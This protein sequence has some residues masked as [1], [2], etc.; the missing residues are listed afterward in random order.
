MHQMQVRPAQIA[1]ADHAIDVVRRSIQ[2]LCDLDHKGDLATLSMWL[3]NKTADNMRRWIA[4]HTVL[5]AVEGERIAGVAAARTDGHI[6]LNY[7][8][9][10]ARF[11]GASKSLMHDIEVWASHRGLK[12]L[13]LYS[14]AT[15]LRF[16]LSSG[17]TMTGSPQSGFGVTTRNPM[18]KAVTGAPTA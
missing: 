18:H 16:Y 15:A 11:K 5:V 4:V 7:V 9:P 12:W 17:W 2:E 14:T 10:E 3:S 1:D 6:L 13:T 8:A